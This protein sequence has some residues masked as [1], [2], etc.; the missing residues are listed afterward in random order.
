LY[1]PN[2]AEE[3]L[4]ADERKD[5]PGLCQS[6]CL[7]NKYMGFFVPY[8]GQ[9]KH[10]DQ[11]EARIQVLVHD[12]SSTFLDFLPF[13]IDT[14]TD[15]T[16]IPRKI[17]NCDYAFQGGHTLGQYEVAGVTGSPVVGLRFRVAMAITPRR[18][19]DAPLSFRE[20]SAIVVEDPKWVGDYA[21]L[22][23]DALRQVVMVCDHD[24]ISLWS[25]PK[26]RC[27]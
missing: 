1:A 23:L 15:V 22:G 26:M 27:Y 4:R 24:H 25:R 9:S 16:I 12:L 14:G 21:L 19:G 2:Y 20:V 5:L 3:I 8:K 11:W 6:D 7:S 10:S 13:V 18:K 17:L